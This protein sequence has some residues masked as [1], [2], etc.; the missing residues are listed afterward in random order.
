MPRNFNIRYNP[1]VY[2]DIQ[3][4]VNFYHERTR[5]DKVGKR[6]VNNTKTALKKLKQSALHYQIRYGDVRLLPIPSFPFR[7][8]YRVDEIN[9]TVYV[10]AIFHTGEDPGKWTQEP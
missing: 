3:K 1:Q 2:L 6:F 7:A 4:A 5:N 9:N 10:E 8:H